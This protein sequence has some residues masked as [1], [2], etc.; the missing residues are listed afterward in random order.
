MED[1]RRRWCDYRCM[2]RDRCWI[3]VASSFFFF[4]RERLGLGLGLGR[5]IGNRD[6]EEETYPPVNDSQRHIF[7]I[8]G[9]EQ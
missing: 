7:L 6:V 2:N 4:E 8:S 1:L 5:R 9:L 3:L